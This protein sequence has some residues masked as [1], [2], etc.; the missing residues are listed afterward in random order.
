MLDGKHI[1]TVEGVGSSDN[2]HPIQERLARM[3]A[4]QCGFCTPGMVLSLYTLLRNNPNPNERDIE[5]AFDG[6]ILT[7]YHA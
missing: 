7:S 5:N 4:T 3:H 2:P 1:V 6:R